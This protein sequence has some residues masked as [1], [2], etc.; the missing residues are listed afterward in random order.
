MSEEKPRIESFTSMG[1]LQRSMS[2]SLPMMQPP[3]PQ[4]TPLQRLTESCRFADMSEREE[5]GSRARARCVAA[6][7]ASL[8][9]TLAVV[10][11]RLTSAFGALDTFIKENSREVESGSYVP[12]RRHAVYDADA[13]KI[14]HDVLDTAYIEIRDG[15]A[16]LEIPAELIAKNADELGCLRDF[17]RGYH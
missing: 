13:L 14:A 9:D 4:P 5:M 6:P 11:E 10:T 8:I 3:S 12:R 7:Q 15:A 17:R 1:N 16:M 2:A